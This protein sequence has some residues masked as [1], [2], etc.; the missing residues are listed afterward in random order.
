MARRRFSRRSR[1]EYVHPVIEITSLT[2]TRVSDYTHV[3]RPDWLRERGLFVAEGR[4]V[5]RRL[6]QTPS[7]GVR[8]V[9]LTST[10]FG[11]LEDVLD[12]TRCPIYV[13]DPDTMKRLAG[14][15]FHHG[16]LAAGDRPAASEPA[17]R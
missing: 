14:F 2:D 6:F 15:N 13:C 8:S 10:A 3:G 16:G 9:L 1:T 7:F 12:R 17:S 5:V 11:A 4:L